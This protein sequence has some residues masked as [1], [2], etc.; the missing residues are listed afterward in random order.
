[1]EDNKRT[2][3]VLQVYNREQLTA[4]VQV[5]KDC[6]RPIALCD[7][8]AMLEALGYGY[9]DALLEQGAEMISSDGGDVDL[10]FDAG[11]DA[12]MAIAALQ[13]GYDHIR[14]T[15]DDAL[16]KKLEDIADSYGA[17]LEQGEGVVLKVGKPE[18]MLA[19]CMNW[20]NT[21]EH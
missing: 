14:F 6:G 10:V 15:G 17:T 13:N 3:P 8:G 19:R 12:T 20:T 1:M 4:A 18:H 21:R 11:M 5:A 9:M 7:D 2:A 16:M